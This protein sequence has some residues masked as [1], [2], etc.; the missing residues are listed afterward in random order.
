MAAAG[1]VT[2]LLFR[3]GDVH[4]AIPIVHV[5]ETLR[6]LPVTPVDGVSPAVLGLAIIRGARTP[7]V[8]V[9]AI[10]GVTATPTRFVTVR[11]DAGQAALAVDE[12]L[13][14]ATFDEAALAERPPLVTPEREAFFGSTL[15]RD[16]QL[17]LVLD[18]ARVVGAAG[19]QE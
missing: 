15:Q 1:P 4:G 10:L 16:R 18:A 8:D 14:L 19:A 13:G 17:F 11:S 12:V 3:I 7:V 2:A 9:G 6:P 5:I